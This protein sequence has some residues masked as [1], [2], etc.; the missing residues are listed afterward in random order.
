MFDGGTGVGVGIWACGPD[1][2]SG[3]GWDVDEQGVVT[4]RDAGSPMLCQSPTVPSPS[5]PVD[6]SI[7]YNQNRA[8]TGA[9]TASPSLCEGEN[10]AKG[11][12]LSGREKLL[13]YQDTVSGK[14]I[15]KPNPKTVELN[16]S[17][18]V[19]D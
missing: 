2:P 8:C 3:Q 18:H 19:N 7:V 17:L 16:T 14:L 12:D 6:Q 11:L 10:I 13:F 5:P 9:Y 1:R 4:S 15:C